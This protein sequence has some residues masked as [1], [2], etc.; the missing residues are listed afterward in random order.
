MKIRRPLGMATAATALFA[1][2]IT[3]AS[4]SGHYVAGVEGLD[5]GSA[6]P[7]GFYY[8]GYLVD[9]QIDSI[10]GAPGENKGNVSA[11]VNR[12]TWI[13]AVRGSG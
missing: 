10:S 6:P 12:L 5:A 11:Y 4:A 7:P 13:G 2:A 9:Y 3:S 8:L 1:S